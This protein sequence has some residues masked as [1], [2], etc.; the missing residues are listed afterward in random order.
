MTTEEQFQ[1]FKE[2]IMKEARAKSACAE[3]YRKAAKAE[4]MAAFCAAVRD[5]FHWL[6]SNE[7]LTG[8]VIDA[9]PALSD[10]GIRHNADASEGVLLVT[11][12]ATVEA[13]GSATVRASGSATV[14]AWGSA[15]I[16][17][18]YG[19]IECQL[20]GNAILRHGDTIKSKNGE[21]KLS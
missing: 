5:N 20:D 6:C 15:Y 1:S 17:A 21:L 3:E 11:G 18:P 4:D 9:Y 10:H 8:D 19:S 7:V 13:W 14:E 12:S 16:H 2:H